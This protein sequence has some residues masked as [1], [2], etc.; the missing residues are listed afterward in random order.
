MMGMWWMVLIPVL[1]L[2]LVIYLFGTHM[3][4]PLHRRGNDGREY[5]PQ[6]RSYYEPQEVE[7]N[8]YHLR[9]NHSVRVEDSVLQ[10][11]N[12]GERLKI[13]PYCGKRLDMPQQPDFCP[14]CEKQI[15]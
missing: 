13:C 5:Y 6:P 10:R 2:A 9:D 11:S 7:Q 15:R 4:D 8:I 12:V 14:Y 3:G 1:L